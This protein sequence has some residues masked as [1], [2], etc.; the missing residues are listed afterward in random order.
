MQRPRADS[1]LPV[2]GQDRAAGD[3]AQIQALR[4]ARQAQRV[5]AAEPPARATAVDPLLSNAIESTPSGDLVGVQARGE[6]EAL[7]VEVED[8]RARGEAFGLREAS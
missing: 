8:T 4:A 5:R 1:P 6:A 7:V 2:P 3:A